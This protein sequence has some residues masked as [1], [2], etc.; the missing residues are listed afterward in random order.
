MGVVNDLLAFHQAARTIL[1]G[2][3]T[4]DGQDLVAAT[5]AAAGLE[6]ACSGPAIQEARLRATLIDN[7]DKSAIDFAHNSFSPRQRGYDHYVCVMKSACQVL[8]AAATSIG[9]PQEHLL[10]AVIAISVAQIMHE[11]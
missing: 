4:N 3:S 8:R 6:P 1:S 7:C 9:I 2:A 5:I 10:T 11:P